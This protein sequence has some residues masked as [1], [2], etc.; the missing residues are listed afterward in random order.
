MYDW[1]C[2]ATF[3]FFI[4]NKKPKLTY[5]SN[6]NYVMVEKTLSFNEADEYCQ[7]HFQTHLATI[8]TQNDIVELESLCPSQTD[9]MIGLIGYEGSFIWRDGNAYDSSIITNWAPGEPNN[10]D[11]GTNRC[12]YLV[13]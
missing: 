10:A 6:G 9:C 11:Y 13:G 1:H 7:L 12:A 8:F 4:C 5:S 3:P 2:T